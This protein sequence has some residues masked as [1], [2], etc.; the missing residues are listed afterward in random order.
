M[1]VSD[2]DASAGHKRARLQR[3]RTIATASLAVMAIVFALSAHFKPAYP[4]LAW[5]EAFNSGV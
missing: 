2:S 1:I 3:M 4:L 5:V